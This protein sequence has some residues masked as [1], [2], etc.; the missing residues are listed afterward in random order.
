[1][2]PEPLPG[3]DPLS[4]RCPYCWSRVGESCWSVHVPFPR[5][6]KPHAARVKL[7][8]AQAEQAATHHNPRREP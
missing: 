4:V 6:V 5:R 8:N 2:S 1:M 7:A 3:V